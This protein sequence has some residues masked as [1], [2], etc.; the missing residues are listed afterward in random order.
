MPMILAGP[1]LTLK[2]TETSHTIWMQDASG[3]Q[4][5]SMV[6]AK[7]LQWMNSEQT[8]EPVPPAQNQQVPRP[9]LQEDVGNHNQKEVIIAHPDSPQVKGAGHA[10]L[11]GQPPLA[12]QHPLSWQPPSAGQ[13][14]SAEQRPLP[15]QT[16]LSG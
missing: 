13:P 14:P 2:K 11:C 15:R 7:K 4:D 9:L 3:M 6:Q 10:P 8:P 1:N 16:H 12:E 5:T